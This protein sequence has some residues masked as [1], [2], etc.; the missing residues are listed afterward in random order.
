MISCSI[1]MLHWEMQVLG[2]SSS[3]PE[4]TNSYWCGASEPPSM[5]R[6]SESP[7]LACIGLSVIERTVSMWAN[8]M[9]TLSS[10]SCLSKIRIAWGKKKW[11]Y[12]GTFKFGFGP[13]IT[14]VNLEN[15]FS[16]LLFEE[17]FSHFSATTL[18]AYFNFAS[19]HFSFHLNFSGHLFSYSQLHET[20]LIDSWIRFPVY[21]V[22]GGRKRERMTSAWLRFLSW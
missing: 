10:W 21:D 3:E 8:P 20:K 13:P 4:E 7:V 14:S 11:W 16:L 6:A 15:F 19:S 2:T 17:W 12:L 5:H 18:L 22:L 1:C 9:G